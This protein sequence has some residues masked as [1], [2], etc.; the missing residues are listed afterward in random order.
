MSISTRRGMPMHHVYMETKQ[1]SL[2]YEKRWN[3]S[4]KSKQVE[5]NFSMT[6]VERLEQVQAM[7]VVI[8]SVKTMIQTTF[9]PMMT[10]VEVSQQAYV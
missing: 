4:S 10:I 7:E 8:L 6:T 1:T 9:C 5:M 2:N 3:I